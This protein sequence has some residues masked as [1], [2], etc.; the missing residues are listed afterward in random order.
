MVKYSFLLAVALPAFLFFSACDKSTEENAMEAGP[1]PAL[2]LISPNGGE[3]Y[4]IGDTILVKWKAN[5]DSLVTVYVV[6]QYDIETF[7]IS[8]ETGGLDAGGGKETMFAWIIP[9]SLYDSFWGTMIATPAS[10]NCLVEISDY[11]LNYTDRSDSPF[12][13]TD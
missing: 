11:N 8:G 13:I 2:T 7:T 10:E 3:N 9:D 1:M 5:P 12:S 4:K 6:L